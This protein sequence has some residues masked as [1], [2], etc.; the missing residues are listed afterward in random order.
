MPLVQVVNL[1]R[2]LDRL[3]KLNVWVVGTLLESEQSIS[4]VDLTGNIAVVMG[5]EEKGLRHK[6]I[7]YCDF[8]ANIPMLSENFGFNV[9]VATGICLY[10]VNRQ[11]I[12]AG[13]PH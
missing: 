11:R 3:R 13:L 2:C 9:S 6:T 7:K 5:S 8:L 4:D 12:L 1:A 10:E